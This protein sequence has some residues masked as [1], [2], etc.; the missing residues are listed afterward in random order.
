MSQCNIIEINVVNLGARW[1]DGYY[2][3]KFA[4]YVD[5]LSKK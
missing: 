5:Y 4:L 1:G 3:Y 2:A